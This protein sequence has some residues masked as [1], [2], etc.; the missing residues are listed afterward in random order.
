[1]VFCKQGW[2]WEWPPTA[3]CTTTF[4]RKNPFFSVPVFLAS[5]TFAVVLSKVMMDVS[6]EG[7][8]GDVHDFEKPWFL[9]WSM[10]VGMMFC[11]I[12][13]FGEM[14]YRKVRQ[15]EKF[16]ITP[17]LY[18]VI[19]APALCDMISTFMMNVGLLW[20]PASIWQMLRGSIII[21]TAIL[22][23]TYRKTKLYPSEWVGVIIVTISLVIVGGACIKT[24]GEGVPASSAGSTGDSGTPAWELVLG[25]ILVIAAQ[26]LQ[27]LQTI[28]EETL[29]H[30]VKAPPTLIV[31]MEGVW[32]FVLCT[33]ISMPI[34][35]V[36]PGPEGEGLHED[37]VDSFIM[38]G[39]SNELLGLAIGYVLVILIFNLYGMIITEVTNAMV[40]N[41]LEPIRTLFIWVT[42]IFIFYV[43]D[44]RYGESLNLWSILEGFGFVVLV[45]GFCIYNSVI[46][47]PHLPGPPSDEEKEPLLSKQEPSLQ[48]NEK[49]DR[50][51]DPEDFPPPTR[52]APVAD[53]D[54]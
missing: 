11:L 31:G 39:N 21:F 6:S 32:G 24:P 23:I 5:G 22:R 3:S 34:A 15:L 53:N 1:M 12:G 33:F 51:S 27:A 37:S 25:M 54:A 48:G 38:L 42:D 18:W 40:R 10:F 36:L 49:D 46:K 13:F 43:I 30:D 45:I 35:Q 52:T 50:R 47:I 19:I 9:D 26:F 4:F 16:V 7:R 41:L 8:Y 2:G 14:L 29:M 20:V 28:V 17:K 44:E